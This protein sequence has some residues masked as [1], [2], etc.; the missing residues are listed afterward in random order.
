MYRAKLHRACCARGFAH[1]ACRVFSS[2]PDLAAILFIDQLTFNLV[3]YS[4]IDLVNQLAFFQRV[5]VCL[6]G[7]FYS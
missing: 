6:I 4:L 3:S 5:A 1:Q 7:G 2:I